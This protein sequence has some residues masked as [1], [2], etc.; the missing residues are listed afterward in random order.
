[1]KSTDLEARV[2]SQSIAVEVEVVLI[3][4]C[5]IDSERY[6]SANCLCESSVT[7]FSDKG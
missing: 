5:H 7:L 6:V 1:M 3:V 4:S 2:G